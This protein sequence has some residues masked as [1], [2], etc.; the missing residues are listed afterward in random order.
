MPF[1]ILTRDPQ[2]GVDLVYRPGALFLYFVPFSV[3]C[4]PAR[5]PKFGGPGSRGGPV[6]VPWGS[7]GGPEG[8]PILG[9]PFWDPPPYFT[10][11]YYDNAAIVYASKKVA[12]LDPP[13]LGWWGGCGPPGGGRP[14]ARARARV[15]ILALRE[16]ACR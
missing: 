1:L 14:Y 4:R 11:S 16:G 8:G 6:G 13:D 3:L 9:P 2:N 15:G 12:D 5:G 10:L 7:R